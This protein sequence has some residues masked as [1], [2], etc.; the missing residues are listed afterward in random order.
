[1]HRPCSST[2]VS[3]SFSKVSGQFACISYREGEKLCGRGGGVRLTGPRAPPAPCVR[4]V[5]TV[6]RF[7]VHEGAVWLPRNDWVFMQE[8]SLLH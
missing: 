2:F 6:L 3:C 1:M 8:A 5:L 7:G 4:V